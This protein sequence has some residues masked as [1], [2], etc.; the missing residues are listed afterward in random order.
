MTIVFVGP[1]H[2]PEEANTLYV[3]AATVWIFVIVG[4]CKVEVKAAGPFQE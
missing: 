3:P 2:P 1:L 4:F